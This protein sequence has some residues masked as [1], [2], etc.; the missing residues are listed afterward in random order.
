M[1]LEVIPI[2]TSD[3]KSMVA[4]TIDHIIAW[5]DMTLNVHQTIE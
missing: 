1:S 4:Y 2:D 3:D 5:E